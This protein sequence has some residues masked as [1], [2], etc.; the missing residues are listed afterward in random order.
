MSTRTTIDKKTG[1]PKY[2]GKGKGGD[3]TG[4][5]PTLREFMFHQHKNYE[6]VEK[7]H[8]REIRDARK[9][10][11]RFPASPWIDHT[12][13]AAVTKVLQ[14]EKTKEYKS[15]VEFQPTNDGGDNFK[16]QI[17]PL[18]EGKKPLCSGKELEI[19]VWR[20]VKVKVYAMKGNN[21]KCFYPGIPCDPNNADAVKASLKSLQDRFKQAFCPDNDPDHNCYIEI[22]LKNENL[23][24]KYIE[25]VEEFHQYTAK[26]TKYH[27]KGV[28]GLEHPYDTVQLLGVHRIKKGHLGVTSPDPHCWVS[29]YGIKSI[30]EVGFAVTLPP[31]RKC[32]KIP[33]KTTIV[34]KLTDKEGKTK[35]FTV[36]LNLTDKG[37]ELTPEQVEKAIK[38]AMKDVLEDSEGKTF[39]IYVKE[40]NIHSDF[41][42]PPIVK[43]WYTRKY[44]VIIV[45]CRKYKKMELTGK[46]GAEKLLKEWEVY[47][48]HPLSINTEKELTAVHEVGHALYNA[49]GKYGLKFSKETYTVLV[50]LQLSMDYH[51]GRV[52]DNTQ[53]VSSGGGEKT[54]V[55]NRFSPLICRDF[56]CS[57]FRFFNNDPSKEEYDGSPSGD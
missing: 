46:D 54:S 50:A 21:G 27:K 17:L 14:D 3:N 22:E 4:E 30:R 52:S 16:I 49:G 23:N 18:D 41:Y 38:D 51:F 37:K 2:G 44:V 48:K 6:I 40:E 55:G 20:R 13:T 42:P 25:V 24:T 45:Y 15:A 32:Y 12:G 11:P 34:I 47:G 56:R 36:G 7:I 28:S 31:V 53:S 33:P 26:E 57:I 9:I 8:K 29:T 1:K 43:K 5:T 35:D 39:E 10:N 19:V